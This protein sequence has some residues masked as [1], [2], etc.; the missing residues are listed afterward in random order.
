MVRI[1]Q[2]YEAMLRGARK[3]EFQKETFE[4]YQ[5]YWD[6]ER[7]FQGFEF[8]PA[9]KKVIDSINERLS[10]FAD[11][12]TQKKY[13]R[14]AL[15][16]YE[17]AWN[18]PDTKKL[19]YL[20]R[21]DILQTLLRLCKRR[22]RNQRRHPLGS[23]TRGCARN[24]PRDAVSEPTSIVV[25][26]W[27]SSACSPQLQEHEAIVSNV[28]EVSTNNQEALEFSAGV[29]LV[30]SHSAPNLHGYQLVL[31]K[32]TDKERNEWEEIAGTEDFWSLSDL[33]ETGKRPGAMFRPKASSN[34]MRT[35]K[36]KSQ[37]TTAL[38]TAVNH[39][40]DEE[41]EEEEI[42]VEFEE[43]IDVG[44]EEEIVVASEEGSEEEIEIAS[45]EENEV[46]AEEE[47]DVVAEDSETED[48]RTI[49]KGTVT[50]E[51]AH[52][53][54]KQGAVHMT[55][56]RDAVSE[57]TSIVVHRWKSS[58]CSPQL[59]EHEAIVSNVIEVSTDSQ[60]ALEFIAGVKLVLSHSA[61]NLHGYELVLFKLTDKERNEWEEIAGTEDFWSLSGLWTRFLF[62]YM[63]IYGGTVVSQMVSVFRRSRVQVW[64]LYLCRVFGKTQF[65]S[66]ARCTGKVE[67]G[68]PETM[69][70]VY[71][72]WD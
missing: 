3:E 60:E 56:P 35:L 69:P 27:K 41:E 63:M 58:A 59:Q 25:H 47:S 22:N 71:L 33:E 23:Q 40:Y 45:E 5:C 39:N 15:W 20:Q 26:R 61:R 34:N 64:P 38:S 49:F 53:D 6:E 2:I 37:L 18:S 12:Q 32:L 14:E 52:W 36:F 48:K 55:F 57:P 31:F 13:Q 68:K 54:I 51:G 21:R 24:I 8:S 43:E 46:G 65:S 30:L 28:I 19:P 70:E 1:V 9:N 17:G 67:L 29:K 16:F 42:V 66:S 4:F 7:N 11:R 72:R 44:S 62:G 50:S 10:D